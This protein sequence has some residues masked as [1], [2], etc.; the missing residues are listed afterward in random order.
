MNIAFVD[1]LSVDNLALYDTELLN[2]M[3]KVGPELKI[4]FFGNIRF[5]QKLNRD[6]C[7]YPIYQYCGRWFLRKGLSYLLSHMKLLIA[8]KQYKPDVVHLQWFR[9]LPADLILLRIIRRMLPEVRMIHTAHN[10]RPHEASP[11]IDGFW[12]AIY[13]Q[14]DKLIVHEEHARS[15]MIH[16]MHQKENQVE[17]VPHGPLLFHV[18]RADLKIRSSELAEKIRSTPSKNSSHIPIVSFLGY[19]RSYKGLDTF[20]EALEDGNLRSKVRILIAGEGTPE[21]DRL[22]PP[23]PELTFINKKLDIMEFLSCMRASD[24]IVLPYH[25]ISQSG[26]LLTAIAEGIPVLVSPVGGMPGVIKKYNAGWVLEEKTGESLHKTLESII[27]EPGV[28]QKKRIEMQSG[29]DVN[30]EW[31]SIAGL[32]LK[33]Y[34]AP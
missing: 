32:T 11:V 10:I 9:F 12:R 3:L 30:N 28:L 18:N 21:S 23:W 33:M 26:L 19:L 2:G 16:E 17:I 34:Q 22:V 14:F 8:L 31:R 6:I 13:H 15:L 24:L 1:P 29:V 4:R 7:F 25:E 20:L 5:D 27:T